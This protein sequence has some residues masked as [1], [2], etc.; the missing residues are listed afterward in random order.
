MVYN[1][2]MTIEAPRNLES[3]EDRLR[4]K[5]HTIFDEDL[6][7]LSV[8]EGGKTELECL[9]EEILEY[10]GKLSA[11]MHPLFENDTSI[12]HPYQVEMAS[13]A[14]LKK[15]L[16]DCN[17]IIDAM[18]ASSGR[19]PLIIFEDRNHMDACVQHCLTRGI[20]IPRDIYFIPTLKEMG[21]PLVKP[22]TE[23]EGVEE[24]HPLVVEAYSDRVS[25][26]EENRSL[27]SPVMEY[28][29][30]R[31]KFGSWAYV[32]SILHDIGARKIFL[33]GKY[34]DVQNREEGK[35][36]DRCLGEAFDLMKFITETHIP[37]LEVELT[38][39]T[40]PLTRDELS[41]VKTLTQRFREMK[42]VNV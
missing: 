20:D 25:T 5:M 40:F 26:K 13:N 4:S 30:N 23:S 10:D 12:P 9:A 31:Y 2:V 32:T 14:A 11:L 36:L 21:T 38:K 37:D 39:A 29:A 35:T 24:I 15:R 33:G 18:L 41:D 28:V 6:R 27:R 16:E 1:R 8:R 22:I 42:E 19:M 3:V 17:V 34:L 7:T